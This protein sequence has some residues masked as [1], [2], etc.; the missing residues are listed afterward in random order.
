M[1]S[2]KYSKREVLTLKRMFVEHDVDGN[3]TITPK[4][5]AKAMQNAKNVSYHDAFKTLDLNGDGV[6]TFEEYIIRLY[7]LATKRERA[8]MNQWAFPDKPSS[9]TA[10]GPKPLNTKQLNEL[11]ELFIVYDKNKNG[12]I[13]PDEFR[14]LVRD[15]GLSADDADEMFQIDDKDHNGV[16]S[17]DEFVLLMKDS[18]TFA[19]DSTSST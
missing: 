19:E 10:V 11:K 15:C 6:L 1:V 5:M 2:V 8:Q 17:F 3:G 14:K 12:E 7:P 4:E 16:V 18:Y 9:I 13:E